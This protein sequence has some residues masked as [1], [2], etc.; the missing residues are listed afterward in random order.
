MNHW[1]PYKAAY[2]FG[3][4]EFLRIGVACDRAWV[5][6]HWQSAREIMPDYSL[7]WALSC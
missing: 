1:R 7:P 3:H 2:D 6:L 5:G 4:E